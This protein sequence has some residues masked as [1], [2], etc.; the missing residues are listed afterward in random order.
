MNPS[1]ITPQYLPNQDN[2]IQLGG[3][4]SHGVVPSLSHYKFIGRAVSPPF[5]PERIDVRFFFAIAEDTL[6]DDLPDGDGAELLELR[7][8]SIDEAIELNL[9]SVTHFMLGEIK[10]QLDNPN[11][12]IDP[13]FKRWTSK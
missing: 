8:P 6:N 3:H 2:C 4:F 11:R 10:N 5:H 9:P 13:L 7:W 12:H 1:E